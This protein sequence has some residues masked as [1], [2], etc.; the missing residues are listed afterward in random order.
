MIKEHF[1]DEELERYYEWAMSHTDE[2]FH[3]FWEKIKRQWGNNYNKLFPP[4]KPFK[5]AELLAG[6]SEKSEL[7]RELSPLPAYALSEQDLKRP[8]TTERRLNLR[9]ILSRKIDG[10]YCVFSVGEQGKV[11]LRVSLA[12]QYSYVKLDNDFYLL[13]PIEGY[14]D[15]CEVIGLTRENLKSLKAGLSTEPG[16]HVITLVRKND[17]KETHL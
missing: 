14:K 17:G 8:R 11:F 10:D 1:S 7:R 16:K 3:E 2:E 5:L 9:P 6:K 15:L 12:S 4:E 13:Q